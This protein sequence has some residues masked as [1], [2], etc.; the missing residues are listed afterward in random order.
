M[1]QFIQKLDSRYEKARKP[2]TGSTVKRERINGLPST[3]H[4]PPN[5]P[6]WMIDPSY[7]LPATTSV[8]ISPSALEAQDPPTGIIYTCYLPTL[9]VQK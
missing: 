6:A 7:K 5:L 9:Y 3:S 4:P 1:N 2:G 8:C